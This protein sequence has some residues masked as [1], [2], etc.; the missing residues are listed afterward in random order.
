MAQITQSHSLDHYDGV[1][2]QLVRDILKRG[3]RVTAGKS[4]S[5]GS[6]QTTYE[7]LNYSFS[8][9]NPRDRLLFHPKRQLNL[10]A[11][12][13]RFIWMMSGSDLL[14]GIEFY[15]PKAR[16]FSDDGLTVPGSSD[17]ARLLNTRS[18]LNQI[19]NVIKLLKTESG[20]RRAAVTIYRAED[21]ARQSRDIPCTM[22]LVFSIRSGG[23]H[24][25][26]L[27]RS[28]NAIRVLPYDLFLFSLLSELIASAVGV[29]FSGYHHFAV[30]MHIYEKDLPLATELLIEQPL[31][32]TIM[33]PMPTGTS[34][35]EL[36][37]LIALENELRLGHAE[38]NEAK[39]REYNTS[40]GKSFSTYWQEFAR[41]LLCHALQKSHLDNTTKELMQTDLYPEF[42]E[43]WRSLLCAGR[44]QQALTR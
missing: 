40:I 6:N 3:E 23:L 8:L 15:D 21:S 17:G 43:P 30:S 10:T 24:T 4:L 31:K 39:V 29:P 34:M 7:I 9:P 35:N 22:G 14:S 2:C 33:A 41:V 19:D 27:M 25:T 11:A 42:Y 32:R 20:T 26:T 13:G 12:V 18:G 1:F 38:L 28:N 5:V 44:P 16:N 36:Q 37:K